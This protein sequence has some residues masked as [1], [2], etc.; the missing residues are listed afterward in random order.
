[1][2]TLEPYAGEV[3]YSTRAL[4]GPPSLLTLPASSA[5]CAVMDEADSP[6]TEG[7]AYSS[8]PMSVCA[9]KGRGLPSKSVVPLSELSAPALIVGEDGAWCKSPAAELTNTGA[10]IWLVPVPGDVIVAPAPGCVVA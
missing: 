9:P 2:A 7:G 5:D 3:P 4:P 1:M 6:R 10:A 8:A